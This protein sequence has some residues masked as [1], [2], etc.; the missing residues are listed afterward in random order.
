MHLL[1]IVFGVVAVACL[2]FSWKTQRKHNAN[3]KVWPNTSLETEK[4]LAAETEVLGWV[5]L[6]LLFIVAL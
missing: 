1:L 2:R 6:L 4:N 5:S 3:E